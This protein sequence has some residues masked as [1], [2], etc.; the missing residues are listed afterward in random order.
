MHTKGYEFSDFKHPFSKNGQAKTNEE[1]AF[2]LKDIVRAMTGRQMHKL[3][4][5]IPTRKNLPILGTLTKD[6]I[7]IDTTHEDLKEEL[8]QRAD[9]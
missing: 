6:I 8:E 4:I 3:Q 2:T 7:D 1:L 9:T 5:V